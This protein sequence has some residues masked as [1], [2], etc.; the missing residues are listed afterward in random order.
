MLMITLQ[1]WGRREEWTSAWKY[2]KRSIGTTVGAV[3]L[4]QDEEVSSMNG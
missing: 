3:V 2:R 4:D 1:S